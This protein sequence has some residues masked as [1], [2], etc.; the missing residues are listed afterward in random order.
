MPP[1]GHR[2]PAKQERDL[3]ETQPSEL[4]IVVLRPTAADSLTFLRVFACIKRGWPMRTGPTSLTKRIKSRSV[5]GAGGDGVRG[6]GDPFAPRAGIQAGEAYSCMRHGE[7]V[8]GS[9][10][11]GSTIHDRLLRRYV[12]HN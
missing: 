1:I 6:V 5:F 2:D 10:H 4:I 3:F 9:G 7:G 12:T 8:V 11:S